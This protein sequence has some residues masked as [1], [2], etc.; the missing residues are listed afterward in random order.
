LS[1]A[2]RV[3]KENRWG[4]QSRFYRVGDKEYPSVTTILSCLGKP[5][6]IAWAAKI[7]R[8]LVIE[9]SADLYAACPS[10]PRMSRT[11]W[12]TSLNSRLTKEKAHSK[13]LKKAG[14]IGSEAHA[15]IEW[16]IKSSL[17]YDVGACPVI[18]PAAQ[19]A[20]GAWERWKNKVSLKPLLCEQAVWSH[21]LGYAGT[22]DLLAEVN[23]EVTL[24]DWKTSKAVYSESHL[25][26]AAYRHA[27]R[28]MGLADKMNGMIVRLPKLATDPDFEVVPVTESEESLMEV[29]ENVL[30]LWKWL[31]Q[32]EVLTE[33]SPEASAA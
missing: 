14:E 9:V 31:N 8:E 17:L 1:K 3:P 11:G 16:T 25:Q 28:E 19:I 21:E 26:N 24:L 10:K 23:G 29:F 18:S 32:K 27:L 12:I 22:M 5:A 13:E 33:V 7:E 30:A 2:K 15:W 20:V 6:L 4:D